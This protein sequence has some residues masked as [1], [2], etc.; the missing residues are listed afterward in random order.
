MT[1]RLMKSEGVAI[2]KPEDLTKHI[3]VSISHLKEKTSDNAAIFRVSINDKLSKMMQILEQDGVDGA[4]IYNGKLIENPNDTTFA[5]QFVKNGD[6]FALVRGAVSMKPIMWQR[7]SEQ[8]LNNDYIWLETYRW[9]AVIFV[10]RVNV[11]FFGFGL[12]SN[13]NKNDETLQI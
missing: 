4:L 5:K 3:L 11:M 12:F 9:E 7:F 13:Y 10:P 1:V 8:D 6:K 2:L